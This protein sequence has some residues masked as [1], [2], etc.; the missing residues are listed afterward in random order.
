MIINTHTNTKKIYSHRN[1]YLSSPVPQTP[2]PSGQG[3]EEKVIPVYT[4]DNIT[5]KYSLD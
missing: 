1:Y 3:K 5:E 2:V 4:V